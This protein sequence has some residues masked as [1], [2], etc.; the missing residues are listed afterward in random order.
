MKKNYISAGAGSG[1]TYTITTDV[2]E[3]IKEGK[4]QPEKVI[5]TTY[6]KAAA[7]ELREKTKKQLAA[8]GKYEE[9]LQMDHALIGTVH[10]VANTFLRKYWYLLGIMPDACAME[11]DELDAYRKMSMKDLLTKDERKFMFEYCEKYNV[12]DPDTYK[13]NYE[14]WKAD[15]CRVLDYMT[16]YKISDEQLENSKELTRSIIDCLKPTATK[17]ELHEIKTV[18]KNLLEIVKNAR[19][20]DK[21]QKQ[22]VFLCSVPLDDIPT[23]ETLVELAKIANER[24]L[25]SC[26]SDNLC[27]WAAEYGYFDSASIEYYTRYADII[28]RIATEWRTKY[29]AYKN[30]NHLIDFNDMEE[31]FSRLLDNEEVRED[32]KA[33]YKQLYVDEFQDSNPI[34]VEIFQKLSTLLDTCYVGDKKQAIY[35]FR[36]SDTDLTTAVSDS[37]NDKT[38]LE[39]SYRSVDTLV[40]FSN[41]IF[42][43]VFCD[44]MSKEE[45]VLSMPTDMSKG[46]RTEVDKP[47]RLWHW[48]KDKELALHIQQFILREGIAPRD[49]AV[50]ARK[51]TELDSLAK[52]LSALKVPVCREASDVRESR[53]SRLLKA[54]LTLVATPSNELAKAEVAYLT[55]PGYN[56]TEI[57]ENRLSAL[58]GNEN[59]LTKVPLLKKLNELR[60]FK[61]EDDDIYSQN[62]LGYQSIGALVESLVIE[63]D[64]YSVVRTWKNAN[65]EES[66]LQVLVDLARKYE[67]NASRLARPATVVGFIKYFTEQKQKGAANDEG[68][69]LFTYHKSKGLEWKVVILLSLDDDPSDDI[70]IALKSMLGCQCYREELPTAENTNP[71]MSISVV[72]NI[73]GKSQNQS[74]VD[75]LSK[76]KIWNDV[77][78]RQVSEAAR[79]LYVGVT[80]AREILIL[81]SKNKN[82]ELCLRWF[83][84]VGAKLAHK[85]AADEMVDIFDIGLNFYVE[86]LDESE[87]IEWP[88]ETDTKVLDV[89]ADFSKLNNARNISPSKAG[90]TNHYIV[91]INDKEQRIDVRCEDDAMMGDFIH[92]VFCCMDSDINLDQIKDLRISYG[93]KEQEFPSPEK[94]IDAWKNLTDILEKK[95]GKALCRH[96]EVPFRHID[97]EGHL[98]S[99]YI[100][101]VWE[102]QDGCVIVDYKTCPGNYNI[103]F[104]PTNEHYAGKHGDQLDCYQR[105]IIAAGK[106]VK[107]KVIYY[108]VTGFMVEVK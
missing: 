49:I 67:E 87:L 24:E 56:L 100:D 12:L 99:G 60:V 59:Y 66:N 73:F 104:D 58:D 108:P 98:V 5:M 14:F 26:E 95:Y 27:K 35:G 11:E 79:L 41:E 76:H 48:E 36:G 97:D 7:Q 50:L 81:T 22:I 105:A 32:I 77:K 62:L 94:L 29:R 61:H 2:A 65:V 23:D 45:I 18:H 21:K 31:M 30:E 74:V 68:V 8:I 13:L 78:Q 102:T 17:P 3:L 88:E 96:H 46:N 64:L 9:A 57:I 20:G 92:H 42:K 43:K 107:A 63:L 39:N 103:V 91:V 55:V 16:W 75:R 44:S 84:A 101:L 106:E 38:T 51:K 52:E 89:C 25:D 4:L 34:Q 82:N 40:N 19:K 54:L 90:K 1:K 28:F 6:T 71:A 72:R 86:K 80:R 85:I 83:E 53:S 37:I 33:R 47:L 70:N 93:I 15:L 69:R 10:S